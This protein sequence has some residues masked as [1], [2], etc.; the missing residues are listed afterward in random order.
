MCTAATCCSGGCGGCCPTDAG[1]SLEKVETVEQAS[2]AQ[3]KKDQ[4]EEQVKEEKEKEKQEQKQGEGE[5]A[6]K[7]YQGT[8]AIEDQ[9][10]KQEKDEKDDEMVQNPRPAWTSAMGSHG[11]SL[12]SSMSS[13]A[14]DL[15]PR[16]DH[17]CQSGGSMID[18]G[19]TTSAPPA[20]AAIRVYQ[21]F[22]EHTYRLVFPFEDRFGPDTP[23]LLTIVPSG[24]VE[25]SKV[26][27]PQK[28][29]GLIAFAY[30]QSIS[31]E[32]TGLPLGQQPDGHIDSSTGKDGKSQS[33]RDTA[34]VWRREDGTNA[35]VQTWPT[36]LNEKFRQD[37]EILEGANPDSAKFQPQA[38]LEFQEAM[39]RLFGPAASNCPILFCH[40]KLAST[41]PAAVGLGEE[42]L[43]HLKE[44]PDLMRELAI[45]S[46]D[47]DGLGFMADG[48][49]GKG[50]KF[51]KH[52]RL[53]PGEQCV[54]YRKTGWDTMGCIKPLNQFLRDAEFH[55]PLTREEPAGVENS[56]FANSP[57]KWWLDEQLLPGG[58]IL[59]GSERTFSEDQQK[60]FAVNAIG[61]VQDEATFR[62][63]VENVREVRRRVTTDKLNAMTI[64]NM[65]EDQWLPMPEKI[66]HIK[67][68]GSGL[69]G[70]IDEAVLDDILRSKCEMIAWDG[71][72]WEETGFTKMVPQFLER[73]SQSKALA[74]VLD[75]ELDVFR[76]S[77]EKVIERY[78]GRIRVV[79][80]DLKPP[81]WRDAADYGI[82]E[83]LQDVQGLPDWAQEYFLMGR[84]ACKATGSKHVF[85]LG[86]GGISAHEAK[87][88][89]TSGM[90]WTI[91]ALSRGRKEAYP[92]LADWAAENPS[93]GVTLR[94]NLDS[95]EAL[96]FCNERNVTKS[97]E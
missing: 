8:L 1:T 81:I 21:G 97:T 19:A 74:F 71:D 3:A 93:S 80:V 65:H 35:L 29:K 14:T 24:V 27:E 95:D 50:Q 57:V 73:N 60:K 26:L 41:S 6:L 4:G 15:A 83:E 42:V 17:V 48:T 13:A 67:G 92:T 16:A 89:T 56:S 11:Q 51:E 58:L 31:D 96:A 86:G 32:L 88:S 75:Y 94:R 12:P 43:A 38:V 18:G 40:K 46:I 72:P 61:Q 10:K 45:A 44:H 9:R 62:T 25:N 85:S 28:E 54:V 49:N 79:T 52:F 90:V 55:E 47:S 76:E 33:L 66:V 36:N 69:S 20:A 91:Y 59:G 70:N 78:P 23:Q 77:W 82:T 84:L 30:T 37:F 7:Q 34:F 22:T 2:T 53:T 5:T 39:V 63:A 68:F 87:A 64:C